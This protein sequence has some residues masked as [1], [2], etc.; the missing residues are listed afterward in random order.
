[1][2]RLLGKMCRRGCAFGGV[3]QKISGIYYG[4]EI[5]RSIGG[6]VKNRSAGD[7][8]WQGN[9]PLW[10]RLNMAAGAENGGKE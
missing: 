3:D 5:S 2:A 6:N 8:V 7:V 9:L 4:S 1:M 10:G